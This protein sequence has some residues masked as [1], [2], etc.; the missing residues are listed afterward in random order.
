MRVIRCLD[1]IDDE[2]GAIASGS[3]TDHLFVYGTLAPGRVNEHVLAELRGAW[4]PATVR[5]ALHPEGWGAA[6]GYPGIILDE[7]G[8]E[9]RGFIFSSKD[10]AAHWTRL[11][12]FEGEGYKRVLASAALEDGTI[13]PAYVYALSEGLGQEERGA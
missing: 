6:V 13:V 8:S 1:G 5:G 9:V 4:A 10:L 12:E 7:G 2:I 11:D 3:M